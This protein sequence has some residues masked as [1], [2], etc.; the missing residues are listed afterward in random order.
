VANN[1]YDGYTIRGDHR[2]TDKDSLMG[3]WTFRPSLAHSSIGPYHGFSKEPYDPGTVLKDAAGTSAV[4]SWVRSF[5]PSTQLDAKVSFGRANI[6]LNDVNQIP[7]GVDW[8]AQAGIQGF[9]KGVTDLYPSFPSFSISGFTGLAGGAGFPFIQNSINYGASLFM[10]RSKH[11]IK[12]GQAFRFYQQNTNPFG[13]SGTFS[14]NGSW[15]SNPA[16]GG[17]SGSGL[18]DYL[19]G[20]PFSG[21]RRIPPGAHYRRFRNS[22]TFVQDDWKISPSVTL[23]LGLRYEINFP[24]VDKYD[25]N[26]TWVPT[27]RDGRGALVVSNPEAISPKNFGLHP[28]LGLTL[29]TYQPLLVFADDVGIPQRA[30][31]FT[32]YMQ[33]APRFGLAWRARKD[34]TVRLGY[35]VYYNQVDGNRETE[36]APPPITI[37]EGDLFNPPNANGG[38]SQTIQ[39]LF[40]LESKFDPIP[41]VAA[42]DPWNRGYGATQQWNVTIQKILPGNISVEGSYVG[43]KGDH[44]QTAHQFN[45]PP[46]GPGAIQPRRPYLEFGSITWNEQAA[47][48]IYH[49]FQAKLERRFQDGV[50]LLGA[51]TWSKAIDDS[52][53]SSQGRNP[54]INRYDRGLSSFDVPFNLTLSSI[55]EMPFFSRSGSAVARSLLSGWTIAG[56]LTLQSGFP[57]TAAWSADVSNTGLGARP[58][59][60]CDGKLDNPTIQRWFDPGCFAAPAQFTFGNSGRNIL[61]GDSLELFDLAIYKNIDIREQHRLQFRAEFFNAANHPNFAL[62]LATIN[63]PGAGQVL[64]AS[65]G[66]ILQFGIKYRF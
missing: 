6:V 2:L 60:V 41:T 62:P 10:V 34:M 59:R 58:V 53:E 29:P 47:S 18:A 54:F 44:L 64:N 46:P 20:V 42:H 17:V 50:T 51:F 57:F 3:R 12:V 37:R 40:P 39:T 36:F 13:H 56:I 55:Y 38:P 19:L 23:N 15:T 45:A 7:G 30:L 4:L 61:R 43:T 11:S 26:A 31:R 22:W 8:T 33:F 16:A 21:G 48:S 27:A 35:G 52:S 49:A 25:Q 28:A 14:S 5:S 24:T 66:R 65:P 9:G 1:D 63:A 32:N